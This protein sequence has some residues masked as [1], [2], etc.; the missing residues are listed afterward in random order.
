MASRRSPVSRLNVLIASFIIAALFKDT[1]AQSMGGQFGLEFAIDAPWRLEP[2]LTADGLSYGPIPIVITFHDAIFDHHRG[3]IAEAFLGRINVGRIVTIEVREEAEESANAVRRTVPITELREIERKRWVSTSTIEPLHERCRPYRAENCAPLYDIT[4]SGEWHALFWYT[5]Q[6]PVTPGRNIQL[7]ITVITEHH[8][9]RKEFT[10]YVIVHAGEAALPRFSD[11]WLYGDLHYHSQMTDNEG[12][13]GYS[14]RNIVR[15]LGA[16]GLDFVFA[17]D[18]ASGGKQVDGRIGVWRCGSLAGHECFPGGS[19]GCMPTEGLCKHFE[20]WE[21]RDLNETRFVYAKQILYGPDGANAMVADDATT[22][23]IASLRSRKILPQVFMGEEVDVWPEMSVDEQ[24]GGAIRFGDGLLYKWAHV[25]N[26]IKENGFDACR[27]KYS[28]PYFKNDQRTFGVLDEQ[29]IPVQETVEEEIGGVPADVL[30]HFAP[31]GT[32]PYGSR[33]HLVYLPFNAAPPPD[34]R[35]WVPSSTGVFGGGTRRLPE[36]IQDISTMGVAF[37]AHPS[38]GESPGGPGPDV[39]PYSGTALNRA[40]RSRSILGLQLWNEDDHR[41]SRPTALDSVWMSDLNARYTYNIP[42]NTHSHPWTW[43]NQVNAFTHFLAVLYHGT[44]T[45]DVYLRKGLIPNQTAVLQWLPAGQPRKWFIAGGSDAHGDLNYRR[46][47]RP[48]AGQ[49]C[50]KPVGD[51]AIGKP[52]NLVLAGQAQGAPAID[53]PNAVRYTNRQVIEALQQGRFSVTDGP[54]IRIAVDRDRNG[55]IGDDDFQMGS[56]FHLFPGEHVPLLVQWE[57]TPEFGRVS[58]VEVYVGIPERTFAAPQGARIL[59]EAP[60]PSPN[61]YAADPAGVLHV[62]IP[63]RDGESMSA[64]IRQLGY[65][66]VARIYLSPAQFELITQDGRLFY[67]RA[68]VKTAHPDRSPYRSGCVKGG[69]TPGNCGSRLAFSNP[70]WGKFR[71]SCQA[72][73]LSLDKDRNGKPDTCER[74]VPDPC[75]DMTR[76][77]SDFV[78]RLDLPVANAGDRGSGDQAGAGPVKRSPA[79]S[80]QHIVAIPE[81][82]RVVVPPSPELHP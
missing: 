53:I 5:P 55:W 81:I 45:W 82:P 4:D 22:G 16:M 79:S 24:R 40:W 9:D 75:S 77:G 33:Q 6:F 73:S 54:A 34:H 59:I 50:D 62:E 31:D 20:A 37:L 60:I 32:R 15:V 35:G 63:P 30:N 66:G 14:Y 65:R 8:G 58:E 19:P 64:I 48:C 12:E 36:I 42:W 49:W 51:T 41:W 25:G 72:D 3:L 56:T 21:A 13:S 68:V 44:Y 80:C 47:G 27:T 52:R 57:S 38:I 17:T 61:A 76:L 74:N 43:S 2:V 71:R 26:C 39:V 46:Y 29:G 28:R 18:H 11:N 69:D 23:G 1:P 10:N 70:V 67:L 7:G 78:I